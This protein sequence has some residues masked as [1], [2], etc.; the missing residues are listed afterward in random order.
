MKKKY[1]IIIGIAL[2]ALCMAV[3]SVTGKTIVTQTP[4]YGGMPD[5]LPEID[6]TVDPAEG[7]IELEDVSLEDGVLTLC[8]RSIGRGNAYV[9][10]TGPDGIGVGK[11][12]YVHHG[13]IITVDG[14]FGACRGGVVVPI[15]ALL[16]LLLL[17]S[18][19]LRKYRDGLRLSMYQYRN[20]L[21]LGLL[22]F[23]GV[24]ILQSVLNVFSFNSI[25]QTIH[26]VTATA[27]TLA[28]I[29]LP[30]AFLVSILVTAS[31]IDLMRHEGRNWRNMLGAILGIFFCVSLLFPMVMDYYLQW[32]AT[33]IDVHNSQGAALYITEAIENSIYLVT[34][35]LEC[36]LI[37]T[38]VL[39]VKA[40]KHIPAFDKDY[41][42]ILGCQIG[43][44][45]SL[46]K[47]L[48]GRTD[49]AIEFAAM[50]KEKTGKDI[51]FVPSGGQ[52]SDEVMAEAAAIRNYLLAQGIPEE[53][54]LAEEQSAST[55]E[56]FRNSLALIKEREAAVQ[57]NTDA[58]AAPKVAFSTTNYHV[59]RSGQLA[60]AQGVPAEGIGSQTKR[61]FWI[62]A[63]VRE[64]I[65]A[66]VSERK[67]H[68]LIIA[69]LVL[70]AI[71]MSIPLYVD[72][73]I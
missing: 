62:N 41:I 71:L 59:F 24:W 66:L 73:N 58:A 56:N 35:Y 18:G 20:V 2:L 42:L 11:Q 23:L 70:F 4:F 5:S 54:I 55:Y 22:V 14:Y 37:A 33:M 38:I 61:Y 47:L 52:G 13:G 46:T 7:V 48:Q 1:Y 63:F 51:V 72:Y 27:S 3:I 50:Q 12:F 16:Y 31:N 65:A 9:E 69:A 39:S 34:A 32:H 40:A 19:S 53:Q 26:S 25:G 15:A 68:I 45:G 17:F 29:S 49:R 6:V 30:A 64:F 36:V 28:L 57:E 43:K 21:Y 67:R 60:F 8:V 10:A 44:D